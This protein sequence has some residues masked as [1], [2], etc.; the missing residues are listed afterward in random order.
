MVQWKHRKGFEWAQEP[1]EETREHYPELFV[2]TD[3][4]DEIVFKWKR[5]VTLGFQV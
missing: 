2:A 1:E 3:F 5:I 4:E